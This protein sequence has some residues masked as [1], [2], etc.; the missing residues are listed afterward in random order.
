MKSFFSRFGYYIF[1]AALFIAVAVIYCKPVL[2]GKVLVAGDEIAAVSSQQEPNNYHKETGDYSWWTGSVF[3]GMPNY[4]MGGGGTAGKVE[5]LKPLRTIFFPHNAIGTL[6]L[7]F[8]CFFI[9]LRCFGVKPWLSIV[10]AFAIAFSSYFFVIIAAGHGS[11]T[12]TIPLVSV[13][14]GAF[15]LIFR[16]QKYGIGAILTMMFIAMGYVTHPQMT[17]YI[18]MMIALLWLAELVMHI[19]EKKIRSFA[20]ATAIFAGATLIGVGTSMANVFYNAEYVKETMRG[21]H[22]D[23]IRDTP[24]EEGPDKIAGGLDISY[25]TQWSYGIDETMSFLI[26]GFMGGSSNY[27]LGTDS[28][29]YKTLVKKGIGAKNARDFCN[30]VPMYWG[31][32]PF[33][34]GNVYMGAIICWLFILGLMIVNGPY[35]W[36]LLAATLFSTA[37]AW[38][39]NW[40]DLTEFFFK[41]FP[42]YSKFRAVSSILIIA[43]IAMPLLG[44]IALSKILEGKVEKQKLV[45]SLYISGGITA[46]VCLVF[47][48]FGGSM[49]NFKSAYDAQFISQIPDWLYAGIIDERRSL[50]RSDSWRS[51]LF[52]ATAFFIL[53]MYAQNKLKSKWVVALLGIL[54]IADMWPVDKRYFNDSYFLSPKQKNQGQYAMMPYEEALLEDPDP[55]FR[56]FNLTS[57]TF[58]ENRTSYYL[59]SIGGYSAAKLRRYQDLITEH[60]SQMHLPVIN[61]LNGKYIIVPGENGE[62]T[63]QLNPYA[64]GNAWF[65]DSVVVVDNAAQESDALMEIDLSN[66]AVTDTT[67]AEYVSGFTPEHDDQAKIKLTKYTP[68][69]IDYESTSSKNGIAV[70]SEIY[71]PHGWKVTI[72]DQP[73]NHFRVNYTL[74]ALS[75][76]AGQHRI[77]FVFDPD[78]VK[79]GN[80]ISSIFCILMYLITIAVIVKEIIDYRKRRQANA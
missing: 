74:R 50:L 61:M 4:Q 53:W 62:P 18:F 21:G 60:L 15:H 10:G 73:V 23:I 14:I 22:S 31:D 67:F 72:D 45:K 34:S 56:V 19:K 43:E 57:D 11:K 54:V 9:M 25:A 59:K 44:F 78:S 77:H 2:S 58:N 39:H 41:Y 75:V 64:L 27:P 65:V 46:G 80:T 32:Q 24:Q 26:P 20:V 1:A 55:H 13:V 28:Q 36:A 3:S 12:I 17:Y 33:T 51:F 69:Y 37:L 48:L 16:R 38:G 5:W 40:M 68:K 63:P 47:A 6:L 70:F 71:Y 79:K 30:A 29:L 66:T 7:Y 8:V 49:F 52:I 76:P 42:L 35:K